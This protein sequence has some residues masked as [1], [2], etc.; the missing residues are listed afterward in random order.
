M[1]PIAHETPLPRPR[2]ARTIASPAPRRGEA[3]A[4]LANGVA[5]SV[6]TERWRYAEYADGAMLFDH[7]ADPH[8]LKNLA[9]DPKHAATVAEMKALLR[10]QLP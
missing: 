8:E 5:K 3:Q 7:A 9:G 10:S 1:G 6:R 4:K 2:A